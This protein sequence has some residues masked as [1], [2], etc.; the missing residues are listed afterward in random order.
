MR[1]DLSRTQKAGDAPHVQLAKDAF[2][3]LDAVDLLAVHRQQSRADSHIARDARA[4]PHALHHHEVA[5]ILQQ[6]IARRPAALLCEHNRYDGFGT[7]R[8]ARQGRDEFGIKL[9]ENLSAC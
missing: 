5:E 9:A 3:L 6:E 4:R 8:F 1:M 7:S 2:C